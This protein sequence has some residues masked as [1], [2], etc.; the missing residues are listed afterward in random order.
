MQLAI[1][2]VRLVMQNYIQS[3]ARY[4]VYMQSAQQLIVS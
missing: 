1:L 4:L 3:C 2:L